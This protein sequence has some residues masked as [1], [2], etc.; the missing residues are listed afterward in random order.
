M[1]ISENPKY[2]S[3]KV[4][5]EK[6][7]AMRNQSVNDIQKK[8]YEIVERKNG[9]LFAHGSQFVGVVSGFLEVWVRDSKTGEPVR[10]GEP[11]VSVN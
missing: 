5:S 6:M 2:Q 7:V 3:P 4:L 11:I 8:F 10:K 9:E 1:K